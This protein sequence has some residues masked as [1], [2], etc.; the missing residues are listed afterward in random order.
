M[1]EQKL[2]DLCQEVLPKKICEEVTKIIKNG[3]VKVKKDPKTVVKPSPV[4]K[5]GKLVG[6]KI[7]FE[8]DFDI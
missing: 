7:V 5:D 3:G 1:S 4:F 6:G 2:N 8:I